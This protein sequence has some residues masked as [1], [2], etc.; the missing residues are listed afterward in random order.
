[1]IY[2]PSSSIRRKA[3]IGGLSLLAF[4]CSS[5]QAPQDD[6]VSPAAA[7]VKPVPLVSGAC[8]AVRQSGVISLE[9]N[10]GFDPSWGV[11]GMKAFRLIFQSLREDG[12]NLNPASR[13]VLDSWPRGRMVA[14]GNG[15]FRVEVRLPIATR[16]GV[17]RLVGALSSAAVAADYTGEAP[18]ATVS[19]VG[20]SY[21]MTVVAGARAQATPLP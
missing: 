16:P 11:T 1:V 20:E 4:V 8:P 14:V 15:Y 17:Y 2:R 21:C 6:T 3:L 9:W 10:P 19:P 7:L 12:V 13:L 5:A 18:R